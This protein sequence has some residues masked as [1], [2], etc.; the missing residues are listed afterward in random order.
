[1]GLEIVTMLEDP[2]AKMVGWAI[3]SLIPIGFLWVVGWVVVDSWR[4]RRR[5]SRLPAEKRKQLGLM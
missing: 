5:I 3:L 2:L 1:M 4:F